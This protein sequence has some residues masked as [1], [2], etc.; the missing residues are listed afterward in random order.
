MRERTAMEVSPRIRATAFALLA[1]VLLQIYFGALVAGL[2]AGLIYNTWPLIDG[3]FIP[4]AAR[5]AHETPLWRN[6]FENTLTVQFTHRMTAYALWLLAVLHAFDVLRH[7]NRGP[8]VTHALALAAL[9]TL[10]AVLGILTLVHQVPIGLA[11]THQAGAILVLTLAV[12]HA[13]R[14]MPRHRSSEDAE[15]LTAA[16]AKT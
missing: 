13:E 8:A 16:G 6:L 9:V 2:R 4:D 14:L 7:M 11:L 3:S 5:L 1:L 15:T 12:V 10:Q